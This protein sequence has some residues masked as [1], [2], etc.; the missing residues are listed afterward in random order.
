[1]KNQNGYINE[2]IFDS[3]VARCVPI[4]YGADN[5]TDYVP[6]DCFINRRQFRSESE[7]LK[8]IKAIQENF[9]FTSGI[10]LI[11]S[12]NDFRNRVIAHT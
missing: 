12:L 3:F 6:Q 9:F 5:I 10:C 11:L 4:Y 7:Y 2:K 8:Y 1:M